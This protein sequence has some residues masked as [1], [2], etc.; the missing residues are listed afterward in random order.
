[1]E[2]LSFIKQGDQTI[3]LKDATGRDM[4]AGKQKKLIAGEGI[5][6]SEDGTIS[7]TGGTSRLIKKQ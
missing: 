1:M 5:S 3:Y 2:E 6:I 4:L 7:A